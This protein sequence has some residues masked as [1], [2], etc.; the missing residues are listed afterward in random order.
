MTAPVRFSLPDG[1]YEVT[2]MIT[3]ANWGRLSAADL[4]DKGLPVTLS[5]QAVA[6]CRFARVG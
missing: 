5:A 2:E 1:E 4:R 6:I 3:K